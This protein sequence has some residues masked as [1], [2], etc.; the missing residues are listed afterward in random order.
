MMD[1]NSLMKQ[2][3]KLQQEMLKKQEELAQK[4]VTAEV[5]GGMV[6]V[7]ANG[8]QEIIKIEI[9]DE[10]LKEDKDMI[11]ELVLSAVN[12]A[13]RLSK[14]MMEKELAKLTGGINIPGLNL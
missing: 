2:A 14:E 10:V 6:K 4:E 9:D 3:A 12:E 5:G 11:E 1:M 7:T 13:L 8:R